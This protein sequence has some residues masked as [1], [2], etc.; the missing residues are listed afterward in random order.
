[1]DAGR[2]GSATSRIGSA[3]S[4][5]IK[6]AEFSSVPAKCDEPA[7]SPNLYDAVPG[8]GMAEEIKL[9][10]IEIYRRRCPRHVF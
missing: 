2:C 8:D 10:L 7:F 6:V 4:W 3:I 5:S 9:I 1:M